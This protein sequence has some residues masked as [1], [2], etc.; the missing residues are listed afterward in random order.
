MIDTDRTLLE[1]R[2]RS[3]LQ[4]RATSMFSEHSA[5][6]PA[7]TLKPQHRHWWPAL[8]TAAVVAAVAV[9][10]ITLARSPQHNSQPA[11]PV[12][13]TSAAPHS[14]EANPA[15]KIPGQYPEATAVAGV[16]VHSVTTGPD[17][18]RFTNEFPAAT[19][20]IEGETYPFIA[21]V[22]YGPAKT[23]DAG[24][25]VLTLTAE[26]AT[27]DCPSPFLIRPSHNY[28]I[29]CTAIPAQ[30]KG[31][32]TITLTTPTGQPSS[33]DVAPFKAA[34]ITRLG[35]APSGERSL[36]SKGSASLTGSGDATVPIAAS[37]GYGR[38]Y[39]A[40]IGG[41]T[42]SISVPG[43]GGFNVDCTGYAAGANLPTLGTTL[44]VSGVTNQHWR[45][46][47]FGRRSS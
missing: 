3:E 20:L 18:V 19:T 14:T 10:A 23:A 24:P 33:V 13:S 30:A 47:A 2:I 38:V 39:A 11:G 9:L 8:A 45:V 26:N 41:G 42:I 34:F 7:P 27:I 21:S 4:L 35:D 40:C 37:T 28:H 43:H 5:V 25:L 15:A 1:T 17:S 36:L 16:T 32:V 29:A 31:S 12:Q 6:P 46:A 22:T 44:T